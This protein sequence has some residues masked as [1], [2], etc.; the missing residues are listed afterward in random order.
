M[1][2]RALGKKTDVVYWDGQ[3]PDNAPDNQLSNIYQQ[4]QPTKQLDWTGI[5]EDLKL[6]FDFTVIPKTVIASFGPR[7]SAAADRYMLQM[8]AR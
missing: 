1:A 6:P 7:L 5:P 8:E 2:R 3:V 4:Q